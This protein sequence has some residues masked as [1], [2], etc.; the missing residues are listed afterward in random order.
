VAIWLLGF[1][2]ATLLTTFLYL[3]LGARE[4]WP[5]SVALSLGGFI[6]VYG[7][8]ERALGVPFPPGNLLAWVGSG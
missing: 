3:T 4:P 6:F 5:V 8:F 7:L 1:P 2:V